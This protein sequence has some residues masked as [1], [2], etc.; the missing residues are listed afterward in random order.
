LT[1]R[2]VFYQNDYLETNY[3]YYAGE[4]FESNSEFNY[5]YKFDINGRIASKKTYKGIIFIAE[6]H[7][8]YND[9]GDAIMIREIDKNGTVKK[10][11]Y[12]YTYDSNNNWTLCVEYDSADN[13]FVRKRE[14][15]YYN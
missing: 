11:L 14:I 3:A 6:T 10:T 15:I 13:I 12:D 2:T 1:S 9:Y 4:K 8:Y 5:R 7:F